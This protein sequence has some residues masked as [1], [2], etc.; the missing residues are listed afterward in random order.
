MTRSKDWARAFARQSQADFKA[1]EQLHQNP[2]L[3]VAECHR[4]VFLQMA[5]EKLCK[6]DLLNSG[7]PLD[8]LQTSHAYVARPLKAVLERQLRRLGEDPRRKQD[9]LIKIGHLAEEIEVLNPAVKRDNRRLDNCEYPWEF[10]EKVLSPLDWTFYLSDL[11]IAPAG[12]T[13]IKLLRSAIV[14]LIHELENQA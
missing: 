2:G 5:S 11:L 7:A 10:G 13:F 3:G 8:S 6:A 4:L 12:R 1:W 9:L 14:T